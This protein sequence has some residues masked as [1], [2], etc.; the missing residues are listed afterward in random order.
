MTQTICS[1]LLSLQEGIKLAAKPADDW[2][3]AEPENR[4]GRY[5]PEQMTA[6]VFTVKGKANQ[7]FQMGE[8][9]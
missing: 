7:G 5:A 6:E 3:P 2:G 9:F 1:F 4:T 8:K